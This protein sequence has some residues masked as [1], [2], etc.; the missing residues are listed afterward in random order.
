MDEGAPIAY[1]VLESDVPVFASGGEQIGKV[2]HVV[3]AEDKDIFHGLVISTAAHGTR[4]VAAE[5]VASL[6]EHGVDLRIESAA[7]DQLPEPGGGAPEY[8]E[9]PTLSKWG[10]W[11]RRLTL[12]KDWNKRS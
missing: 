2:H 1:R 5:E 4:F 9:D 3:A 8:E 10:H 6:H 7:V 12:R 11:A